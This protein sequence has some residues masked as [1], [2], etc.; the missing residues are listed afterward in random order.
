MDLSK[1]QESLSNHGLD[2][3]YSPFPL[4]AVRG[5]TCTSQTVRDALADCPRLNSNGKNTKSTAGGT[6]RWAGRTVRQGHTVRPPGPRRLSAGRPQTVRPVHQ[7]AP[8]SV[9]NNEPSAWGPRT[10]CPEAHFL[11]NFCQKSQILNK[12][13]KLADRPPQG[14]GLSAQYLKTVFS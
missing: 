3:K 7:A 6:D 14:P 2:Y 9:K 11:E 12:Y 8:C 13:H 1:C 5:K 4:L 10:V